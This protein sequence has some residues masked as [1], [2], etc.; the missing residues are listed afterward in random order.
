MTERTPSAQAIEHRARWK[1]LLALGVLLLLLGLAGAGATT[2]LELTSL[3]VFG[4]L[5]LAS[6]VLQIWIGFLSEKGKDFL[7]HLIAAGIET[8]LGFFIM[9]NPLPALTDL[10]VLIGIFLLA[11]GL[12]R[13]TRSLVTPSS[14]Q[15]WKFMAGVAAVL[16][17]V[18]VWL[19]LPVSKLWLVGLCIAVDFICHGV[20]WVAVGLA[21]RKP[22]RE[23]LP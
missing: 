13:L 21:E 7:L 3:L 10:V 16:L 23:S 6:G 9:A 5:L 17:G 14:G 2:L 8:A 11:S 18:C 19:A 12:V 4:P 15:G 20:S 1:W 22:L